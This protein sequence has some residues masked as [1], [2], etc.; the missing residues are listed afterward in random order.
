MVDKEKYEEMYE[1]T[2]KLE[3]YFLKHAQ[4]FGCEDLL[5]EYKGD[6]F[7]NEDLFENEIMSILSEYDDYNLHSSLAKKLAWR[8]FRK[9]HSDE[10]IEKMS[11][12]NMGYFGVE[13]YKYEEKYW[14][15]FNEHGYNRL[16]I[17]QND[18]LCN[19]KDK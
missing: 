10:E 8:D 15:E 4:N 14:D 16:E 9:E 1:K 6:V 11:E 17:K 2:E 18:I 12:E 3:K 19:K 7:L 13:L 5:E